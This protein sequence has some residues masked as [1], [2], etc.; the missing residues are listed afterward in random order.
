[1]RAKDAAYLNKKIGCLALQIAK[2]NRKQQM[3][4]K[5][6]VS[7]MRSG[8]SKVVRTVRYKIVS[9]SGSFTD[10]GCVKTQENCC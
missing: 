1:M 9:L 4:I 8:Y 2:P 3:K 7:K 10:F 6:S 5:N